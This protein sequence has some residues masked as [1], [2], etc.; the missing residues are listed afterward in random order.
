MRDLVYLAI[1]AGFFLLTGGFVVLC[2]RIIGPEPAGLTEG[3]DGALESDEP[4]STH[5]T[6]GA[7]R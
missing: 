2:D 6:I 3:G 1:V 4:T 7:T 5:T